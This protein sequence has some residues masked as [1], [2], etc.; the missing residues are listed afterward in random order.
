MNHNFWHERWGSNQIGFHEADTH[1]ML[2][3]HW[4][5]IDADPG[6][7]VLAPLCGKSNDMLWLRQ[8]GHG[9]VG[10]ELSAIA[11]SAFF[12]ENAIEATSSDCGS[13]SCRTAPGYRL[14]CGDF[15]ASERELV[16]DIGAVYDRAALIALAPEQ[17]AKY[18]AHLTRLIDP[19][20]Q[21]LLVA[22]QYEPELVSPPPFIVDDDEI[23]VLFEA[24]YSI[25]RLSTAHARVKGKPCQETA[26]RMV[27][28]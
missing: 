25:E 21:V 13:F 28:K 23:A 12:A 27:R 14:L 6:R 10:I 19:G 9:V 26:Y 8:R 22:L 17:R 5:D 1:P 15:F 2:V 16:G 7:S 3:R 4:D 11:I 20:T 24:S 18:I